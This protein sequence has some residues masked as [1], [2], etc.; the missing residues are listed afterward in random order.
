MAVKWRKEQGEEG[1]FRERGKEGAG[2]QGGNENERVGE[3]SEIDIAHM[4][5][6]EMVSMRQREQGV[7]GGAVER[8]WERKKGRA[9]N[10]TKDRQTRT[11]RRSTN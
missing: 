10:E 5:D 3:G 8:A 6:R 1:D 4:G 7:D 9:S 2:W 11:L